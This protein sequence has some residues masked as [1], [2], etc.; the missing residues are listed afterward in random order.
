MNLDAHET[1]L[2]QKLE[3]FSLDDRSSQLQSSDRLARENGWSIEYSLQVVEE[4]TR[5]Y[6]FL[7]KTKALVRW[8]RG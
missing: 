5:W 4:H 2:Y 8:A 3:S 1:E 6:L 7:P